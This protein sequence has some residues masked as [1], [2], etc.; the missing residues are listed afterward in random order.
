MNGKDVYCR[1]R[2]VVESGKLAKSLDATR[3]WKTTRV[4]G[5]RPHV[6]G[7]HSWTRTGRLEWEGR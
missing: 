6:N 3:W 2:G 1:K 5:P 4:L 7:H